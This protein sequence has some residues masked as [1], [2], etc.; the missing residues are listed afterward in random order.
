MCTSDCYQ[1]ETAAKPL[2]LAG[3]SVASTKHEHDKRMEELK[4]KI[5]LVTGGSPSIGRSIALAFAHQGGSVVITCRAE[6][7]LKAVAAEIGNLG[8]QAL[9]LTC[10]VTR[11]EEV[12]AVAYQIRSQLG[13]VQ[14]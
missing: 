13:T 4:G 11:R 3:E 10:D 8:T 12:E 2:L 5:V 7:T 9:P 1:V 14:I 6:E